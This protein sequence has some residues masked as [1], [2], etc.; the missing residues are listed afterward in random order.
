MSQLL[1][2]DLLGEAKKAFD[3]AL[4]GIGES[5]RMKNINSIF[6]TEDTARKKKFLGDYIADLKA[7]YRNM[8]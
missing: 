5:E 4:E 3:I 8:K 6:E 1:K 2:A 7:D